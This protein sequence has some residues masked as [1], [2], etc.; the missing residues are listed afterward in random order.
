MLMDISERFRSSESRKDLRFIASLSRGWE[1]MALS[2]GQNSSRFLLL[3]QKRFQ[4]SSRLATNRIS[5]L[6]A[7]AYAHLCRGMAISN[8]FMRDFDSKNH[9]NASKALAISGN[10][11]LE[12]GFTASYEQTRAIRLFLDAQLQLSKI[13]QEEDS[14][15]RSLH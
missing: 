10:H 7:T 11:F 5:R 6:L 15:K 13:I 4:R 3:A 2:M 1:A 14:Q 8:N 12:A 9:S